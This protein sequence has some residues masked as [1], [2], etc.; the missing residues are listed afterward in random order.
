MR[1]DDNIALPDFAAGAM[2]N[3]GLV[4]YRESIL[5]YD[6]EINTKFQRS[7]S[8]MV[9]SHELA[10]MVRQQ[11]INVSLETDAYNLFQRMDLTS[12]NTEVGG[13][14][15]KP[16]YK[17]KWFGN[18]VSPSWWDDL[19]LN[20]G[21][22]TFM[23]Y[24][25]MDL[26]EKDWN[27]MDLL[28]L[29]AV[30]YILPA[31]SLMSSH[32]IYVNVSQPSEIMALFDGITYY[33]GAS[34]IRMMWFFL[35]NETFQKGMKY[36]F[37]ETEKKNYLEEKSY[38]NAANNDLWNALTDVSCCVSS[39]KQVSRYFFKDDLRHYGAFKS[40]EKTQQLLSY[41]ECNTFDMV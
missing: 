23:A 32:P 15:L 28:D 16:A 41:H 18:L 4:T 1:N 27:M 40:T 37:F 21:F 30:Q 20:E 2:E 17:Y 9:V 33:K 10:H 8:A 14:S 38:S 34:I 39:F 13:Y 29:H 35:G 7:Y 19:W 6:P 25:G 22:A 31:D 11:A 24:F 26:V 36:D 5:L 3:W 12:Y